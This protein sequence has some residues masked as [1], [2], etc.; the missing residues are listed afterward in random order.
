MEKISTGDIVIY[1]NNSSHSLIVSVFGNSWQSHVG[2]II[3]YFQ[4]HITTEKKGDIF[5]LEAVP[6]F[7]FT[8]FN[9]IQC[10]IL[11]SLLD[12]EEIKKKT[13][14]IT[15][16]SLKSKY[17]KSDLPQKITT[18]LKENKNIKFTDSFLPFIQN[19]L[20]IPS[21]IKNN[22]MIC[23]EFVYYFYLQVFNKKLTKYAPVLLKPSNFTYPNMKNSIFEDKEELL[24]QQNCDFFHI[25]LPITI[26]IYFL[27]IMILIIGSLSKN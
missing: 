3:R 10:P 26:F 23:T 15:F 8:G 2:V 7:N 25:V 19:W 17:I 21:A 20:R 18:F 4:N 12:F 14:K 5:I 1:E 9:N 11:L 6:Y 24:F 27:L 22:E 13:T 16:R